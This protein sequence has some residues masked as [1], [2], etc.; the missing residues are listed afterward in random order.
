MARQ[1]GAHHRDVAQQLPQEPGEQG[2]AAD[3]GAGAVLVG[4]VACGFCSADPFFFGSGSQEEEQARR[5]LA[6]RIGRDVKKFWTKVDKIISYK[7]KL[8]SDEIR[9]ASMDRHLKHLVSQTE[10]YSAALAVSL[11]ES[12]VSTISDAED[13][14]NVDG[15][16]AEEAARDRNSSNVG[17]TNA[18]EDQLDDQ[19]DHATG[20]DSDFEMH[21]SEDEADDETTIEVE[22]AIAV[23][24]ANTD[25]DELLM[26]ER[27][28]N[29]SVDELRAHYAAI[30]GGGG[31][32]E[33]H[34]AAPSSDEDD[35]QPSDNT[36]EE[37]DET[38]IAADEARITRNDVEDEVRLLHQE[39]DLPIEELRARYAN[40][41]MDTGSEGEPERAEEGNVSGGSNSD[42]SDSDGEFE[43][44]HDEVDDET[45]VDEEERRGTASQRKVD[46]EVAGLLE[47]SEMSI[48]QLRARYASLADDSNEDMESAV[49][50]SDIEDDNEGGSGDDEFELSEEE[51]DDETTIADE[52][53]LQSSRSEVDDEVARLLEESEMSIEQLREKYEGH[54]GVGNDFSEVDATKSASERTDQGSLSKLIGAADPTEHNHDKLP[55]SVGHAMTAKTTRR[56]GGYKRP[57]ILTS[58]LSLR[59]YQEAGVNWLISMCEKRINGIL[60]DEMGLGKTIQ[61]ITMLAHLACKRGIWGPHL[62]VVP[63]SCLVNWEMEFKRWCPAFKVLTY[64]GSAKRRKELRQG[65]SKQNAFQVCITSYQLVVQDAHCFKRKK[66]YYL[67][68]DEAHNI[69]NWKSLRW[70][71]LLNFS[72]QR[73]LLLTG[74]PL[75]NNIMELWAL[76]HFLMPHVFA[77][78]KEFTYWFQNPLSQMVEG[79]QDV[80]NQLVSQLHGIIRPFVLRRLKKDVA[81]Q[82]PG[83][84]EHVVQC[85]LSKRQRFLYEDF[86]SRSSTRRAMFGRGNGRGANFMSMMNVLMQL[87]KV[88]N[89]PDLFEPRPIV[90]PF[91]MEPIQLHVPARCG[92]IVDE[93]VNERPTV[94]LW[95]EAGSL[96]NLEFIGHTKYAASR[97][98]DLFYYDLSAAKPLRTSSPASSKRDMH[99]DLLL[100]FSKLTARRAAYWDEKHRHNQYLT[101][102]RVELA[103]DPVYGDDLIRCCSLPFF[104]SQAMDVHVK[105]KRNRAQELLYVTDALQVMVKTPEQRIEELLPVVTRALCYVPKARA[106]IARVEYGGGGFAQPVNLSDDF[107][108]SSSFALSRRQ[109]LEQVIEEEAEPVARHL[110][111]PFYE[112]FKRTQLFFPDKRLIQFDCGKLQQLDTLLREL[113]RGG[114]RCLIF[115]QMSSMLNILEIFLN[116]HGHT[117]FRLDGSTK[118]EK[119]QS[120]M[121]KFNR[122]DKVF[123]FILSTRSGGLGINLTGADSV[124][125]YDSDWNPAMDA[126]AQDRAHRIGQTRDVHI[127]R[128]VSEHTVEENILRKAQQK[129]HLDFLVMAEGQFTTDFFSKSNL[130]ELVTGVG[131]DAAASLVDD[132]AEDNATDSEP[133]DELSFDA[134]ENAMAQL[135]DEEDVVAMKG[136][137]AEVLSEQ[138]EFD[139]DTGSQPPS[140]THIKTHAIE[141]PRPSTPSNASVVSSVSERNED[142]DDHDSVENDD[143]INE[144][145]S[146]MGDDDTQSVEKNSDDESELSDEFSDSDGEDAAPRKRKRTESSASRKTGSKKRARQEDSS[147]E[148]NHARLERAKEKARERQ[149]EIEE[150]KKLQA[151]KESVSSLKGFEDSLNPVDRY[152]LHFRE[153]IDPLYAYVPTAAAMESHFDAQHG[154]IVDIEQI[155]AEKAAEEAALIADGELIAGV[156]D[157]AENGDEGDD[158]AITSLDERYSDLY[159]KERAHVHFERRKR[160]LTGSAWQVMKCVKT[161]F[162]FYF[163]VDTREAVWDRPA[164]WIKNEQLE[165]AAAIG[166]AGLMSS[167]LT[168]IVKFLAPYPDR[169][170]VKLVCRSWHEAAIHPSTFFKI[171][172]SDIEPGRRSLVD[173]LMGVATGSTVLFGSG[174]YSIDS[175]V[176]VH[177]PIELLA[178]HDTHVELQMCSP[179]AHLRWKA[180]GGLVRG[181]HLSRRDQS[182]DDG[183]KGEQSATSCWQ[184]LISVVD[185]GQVR[186]KFC[187]L[188]G[189]SIGNACAAVSGPSSLLVMQNNRI[190]GS[191]SSG[192]LQLSGGLVMNLNTIYENAHSGITVLGGDAV[193]RRNKIHR[194]GRFG[195][196]LF[197]HANNV[198]VEENIVND[199]PCGNIDTENS[200]RRFVIRWNDMRKSEPDDLP[201]HHGKVK[202]VTPRIVSKTLPIL[203]ASASSSASEGSSS[204]TQLPRA[205]GVKPGSVTIAVNLDTGLLVPVPLPT[206]V[207]SSF[208]GLHLLQSRLLSRQQTV[209]PVVEALT[210]AQSS[211]TASSASNLQQPI[212]AATLSSQGAKPATPIA[213]I[214]STVTTGAPV[215]GVNGVPIKRRKKR[216]KIVH[217]LDKG[218]VMIFEDTCEKR[219]EKI[220]KP[221]VPKNT[222][223]SGLVVTDGTGESCAGDTASNAS[224]AEKGSDELMSLPTS[225]SHVTEAIASTLDQSSGQVSSIPSSANTEVPTSLPSDSK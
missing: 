97:R 176:D 211:T 124:I 140:H 157:E 110:L 214:G 56:M 59:E 216:Q 158:E 148:K 10:R 12:R 36:E 192:V 85:K 179:T 80:N 21:S 149:I 28:A 92:Y 11:A 191:G 153:E 177:R 127:Y 75:Q 84:F 25:Q 18:D 202:L 66:W 168:Q 93:L 163:N 174:V 23:G 165:Q 123:C 215:F 204:T 72:S 139:E 225:P 4:W 81:K 209:I 169:H 78:R 24:D 129:R 219:G 20:S 68:L 141:S 9:K 186:V 175:V 224:T 201:H 196:R 34:D 70:Q 116:I 95:T 46:E 210:T 154:V 156:M 1:V 217:E 40:V 102:L 88:C 118:V 16:E 126:Q 121:D 178:A 187:D 30:E 27:E 37:D 205:D 134:V 130:R 195:I 203:S 69:K 167:T 103:E 8:Q 151:W 105:R 53:R 181:F 62:I 197:Y 45:T 147:N 138:R 104:I 79:E 188:E 89:H 220:K 128:L 101:R 31:V 200:G 120:L 189:N 57:Y 170:R 112:S 5:R 162:P 26:L 100:R 143:Q 61:T 207:G 98:R 172:A 33:E 2:R 213:P 184:H 190:Y 208:P 7:I 47:E 39:R 83:K 108:T 182:D 74:T 67:I 48:E 76:M 107:E 90:A 29:M 19:L 109:K 152:A 122:D 222:S 94:P 42:G 71:T 58:R 198:V 142:D 64:F 144:S 206:A 193:L 86:I 159:R 41:A 150:E 63:T 114:H 17:N 136:A 106:N 185:G 38:T 155:E 145:A 65:W 180:R 223:G 137:K 52:E 55:S 164:V 14:M 3:Q 35:Y 115:T 49:R 218:H 135:E 199:H 6:A 87:R 60:A 96:V 173:I 183:I 22:E 43:L 171:N 160:Q 111:N 132:D 194:N 166:Y 82:M 221:R 119:R 99:K 13:D 73:R 125:F 15:A 113:K 133:E 131:D 117:Y 51:V 91:D 161:N 146:E 50:A 44:S 54:Q 77:S 212:A 32:E